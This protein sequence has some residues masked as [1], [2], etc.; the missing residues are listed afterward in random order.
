MTIQLSTQ[1]MRQLED[2]A[3][4]EQRDVNEIVADAIAVYL[5]AQTRTAQIR[6]D[7]EQIIANNQILL[8][9]LANR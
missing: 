4:Q 5:Q 8:D 9:E 7:V 1:I 3:Q 6:H 2:I